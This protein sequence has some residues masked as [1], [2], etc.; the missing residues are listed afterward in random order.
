MTVIA[1][2]LAWEIRIAD[3]PPGKHDVSPI[4]GIGISSIGAHIITTSV[5][6]YTVDCYPAE[7][8]EIGIF[9]NFVRQIWEFLGKAL[10]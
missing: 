9:A 7:S 1:G 8:A 5:F 4:V 3:V 2:F 6:T 10:N